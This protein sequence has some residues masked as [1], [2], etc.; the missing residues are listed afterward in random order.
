[1]CVSRKTTCSPVRAL[2]LWRQRVARFSHFLAIP[3]AR[4]H[5][6]RQRVARIL[7]IILIPC[8]R[9][10]NVQQRAAARIPCVSPC[11]P[12]DLQCAHPG[13]AATCCVLG[14]K[15]RPGPLVMSQIR[16]LETFFVAVLALRA[17]TCG[18]V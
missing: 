18:V 17:S 8:A 1:M 2:L 7:N 5:D 4:T 11:Y 9:I 16:S 14:G 3:C 6:V 12:P 13:C 10:P 15:P